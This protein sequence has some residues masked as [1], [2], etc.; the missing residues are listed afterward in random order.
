MHT[1]TSDVIIIGGGIAGLWTH[2]QLNERG[3]YAILIDKSPI[4]GQQTFSSQGI[5]HGGAKYTLNGIFS[6][7][8]SAIADMPK[9]W[10]ACLQGNGEIDLSGTN[11]LS[12][13]QLMW[14]TQGLSS[15]LTSFFSSKALNSKVTSMLPEQYPPVFQNKG[16]KG[17]LYQLNEP[18]LDVPSL[19]KHLSQKW[20][21]RILQVPS[22]YTFDKKNASENKIVIDGHFEIYTKEFILTG[23]EGNEQLLQNLAIHSPKMQRRPLHMVLAKSSTLPPLYAHCIRASPKPIATI[24]SHYHSDGETVW[25][26]GGNI[27]EDGVAMSSES[28]ISSTQKKLSEILPWIPLN[29]IKWATYKVNRAEPVQKNQ[30]RPDTTFVES[31]NNIHIAWPTKLALTPHLSDQLVNRVKEK[32]LRPQKQ[33]QQLETDQLLE[34]LPKSFSCQLESSLWERIFNATH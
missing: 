7:A 30:L 29:T 14:S 32:Q 10:Q 33:Q 27:A 6:N 34:Q 16:F 5:I 1:F 25:Y 28:L 15:K 11:I 9:R 18:V 21:H 12:P 2:Y 20:Q 4:G 22:T 13:N 3:L 26:I 31:V 24:T 8:A 17:H 19:V 23:G